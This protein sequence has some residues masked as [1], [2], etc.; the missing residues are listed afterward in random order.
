MCCI[1]LAAFSHDRGAI[2]GKQMLNRDL[3]LL[4]GHNLG[5][6]AAHCSQNQ[7]RGE[8]RQLS[9]HMDKHQQKRLA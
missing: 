9:Y 6:T 3:H 1:F 8:M 7:P 2:H 5:N 4:R